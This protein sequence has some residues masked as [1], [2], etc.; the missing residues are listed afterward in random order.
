MTHE[1]YD[2]D[3]KKDPMLLVPLYEHPADRP[4]AWER[5]IRCADRLHSV[6]LN[7]D[8]GPGAARDERF[9]LV[10]ERLREAG[11]PVLG[12][13]DTDYGRRPHA[14]V[15]QD[16]L[17][18]RDWYATDGAFLDQAS[19]DPELLPHYRRLTV[20]ARAAGAHTLVL[21]HGA[22]PHP[23]YVELADLL[24]TFE[25]PW[26]AYREASAPPP[27]TADH[28]AQRFCHLVYAV[29]PGEIAARLAGELAEQRGAGVHCAVPGSGP[30]PWGT[31]PYALEAAG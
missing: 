2:T 29:P 21:N 26:D 16:L 22:H 28:P 15:V 11:V 14:A 17:R 27:W 10:A 5:L 8:S 25:G 19:A 9:A 13:V 4:D 31:L 7:P 20:A 12:Y 24:V 18:H 30:H 23:G 1:T 3:E 6:V